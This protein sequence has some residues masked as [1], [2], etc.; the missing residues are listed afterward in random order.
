MLE[1]GCGMGE[2]TATIA[3]AHP[4]INFLGCEVFAAGVGALSKLLNEK[5]LTNVRIC[6]HDAMEVVR[7]MIADNSL[8]GIHVY[9]PDPWRKARH[10]KRRLI[11]PDF[12][13]VLAAKLVPRGY[14]HC[15]TDWENYAEQMLEVLSAEPLLTNA[16][17]SGFSP[18]MANPL[19]ERPCTKFQA[20]G[21]RLGHG[22]WDLVYLRKA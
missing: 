17:G 13:K 18:V 15:A 21:E 16:H 3:E 11:R 9:F 7:D 20:R 1:I 6:R 2:T 10:H 22:V 14:I 8:A 4:E 12:V 5:G 19:C